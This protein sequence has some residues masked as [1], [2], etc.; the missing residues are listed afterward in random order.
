MGDATADAERGGPSKA[1]P[2]PFRLSF[3]SVFMHADAADVALM[4]IGLVGAI[5]DGV[6][7]PVTLILSRRIF[8]DL[9]NGPD[10]LQEFSSKIN[11]VG[12]CTHPLSRG[13][14]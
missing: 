2:P 12:C 1:A 9:G 3:A 11:E 13:I 6:S 10:L 5:G 8:N 4:V 7:M 14:D